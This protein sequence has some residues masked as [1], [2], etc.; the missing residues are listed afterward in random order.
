MVQI[1]VSYLVNRSGSMTVNI[2]QCVTIDSLDNMVTYVVKLIIENL[3]FV[4]NE[5][6]VLQYEAAI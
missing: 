4:G 3:I 2:E 5:L 6:T 1:L